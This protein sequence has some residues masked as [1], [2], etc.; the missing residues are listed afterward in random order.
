MTDVFNHR[1]DRRRHLVEIWV[2]SYASAMTLGDQWSRTAIICRAKSPDQQRSQREAVLIE[3]DQCQND[4]V[5][6]DEHRRFRRHPR[7]GQRSYRRCRPSHPEPRAEQ[8]NRAGRHGLPR[9]RARLLALRHRPERRV[10]LRHHPPEHQR[11][12]CRQLQRWPDPPQRRSAG[13]RVH[14]RSG[15]QVAHRPHR[16]RFVRRHHPAR[17]GGETVQPVA[18]LPRE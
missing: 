16:G 11:P 8:C 12:W 18:H 4:G 5:V 6:V 2:E 10:R 3:A 15:G 13:Q 9:Q 1:Q 14:R 7:R 17:A